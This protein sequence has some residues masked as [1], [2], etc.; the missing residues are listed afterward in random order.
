MD[1]LLS[2]GQEPRL[3]DIIDVS[4]QRPQPS[5][6]Q[7]ENWLLDPHRKWSFVKGFGWEHLARIVDK[8]DSLW[9]NGYHTRNG[10]NDHVPQPI[11][12]TL[13]SSLKLIH[14]D[15]MQLSIYKE[16]IGETYRPNARGRFSFAGSDYSLKVTDPI[17]EAEFFARG[18]GEYALPECYLT[19]SLG[20][21]FRE[22]CYKL[23]AAVISKP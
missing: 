7:R 17:I 19:I 16:T 18:V 11:A 4:V 9:P 13:D 2:N 3:L 22:N 20:E 23:I 21:P 15:E 12:E 1:R 10:L 8:T 14:V 6:Y 5:S